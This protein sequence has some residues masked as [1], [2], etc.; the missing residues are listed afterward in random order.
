MSNRRNRRSNAV[1]DFFDGFN[2]G[3]DT[4]GRVTRDIE[5]RRVAEAEPELVES[6]IQPDVAPA[7]TMQQTAIQGR[8]AKE[9]GRIPTEKDSA[10]TGL[11]EAPGVRLAAMEPVEAGSLTV[12]PQLGKISM[13]HTLAGRDVNPGDKAGVARA[14][15][16]AMADVVGKTDPMTANR[17]RRDVTS[18]EREDKRFAREEARADRDDAKAKQDAADQA[19]L[20]DFGGVIARRDPQ[21]IADFYN[22]QYGDGL[23]AQIVPGQNGGFGV[24]RVGKD[25][26]PVDKTEFANVDQ[27][28]SSAVPSLLATRDPLKSMALQRDNEDRIE[29]KARDADDK[30]HRERTTT[31]SE[32]FQAAQI[33]NMEA[34]RKL[35]E[36]GLSMQ[37]ESLRAKEK[38]GDGSGS[39]LDMGEIDKALQDLYTGKDEA[40]NT[41]RNTQGHL[42]VREFARAMPEASKGDSMG[43]VLHA[44]QRYQAAL[45]AAGGDHKKAVDLLQK[46]VAAKS[47]PSA[48]EKTQGSGPGAATQTASAAQ[49]VSMVDAALQKYGP[50]ADAFAG[51]PAAFQQM[52][53]AQLAAYAKTGNRLAQE[54]IARRLDASRAQT[55]S[56]Q[57]LVRDA[58]TRGMTPF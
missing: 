10:T 40:G 43:A 37:A 35:Q 30:A 44:H 18:Q 25:G 9:T 53:T 57:A 16:L 34:Q 20:R 39:G 47:A 48:G 52:N 33:A 22:K 54:E 58:Q 51:N 17:M 19:W 14:R 26:K 56:D 55:A 23:T 24:V 13:R 31:S 29:R 3:Y 50:S 32:K 8:E 38:A 2:Q 1:S 49:P 45:S 7:V 46:W 6:K 4:V 21:A 15:E 42:F 12:G 28:I 5:M 36:R 41:T 27:F 11:V